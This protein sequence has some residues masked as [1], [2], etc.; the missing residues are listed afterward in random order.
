MLARTFMCG[1]FF[2]YFSVAFPERVASISPLDSP[3]CWLRVAP[4]GLRV[5]DAVRSVYPTR[6]CRC[7]LVVS[8]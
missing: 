7:V 3:V 5:R 2:G 4:F 8:Y 1:L 6:G